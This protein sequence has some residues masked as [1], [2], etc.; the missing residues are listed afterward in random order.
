MGIAN[1]INNSTTTSGGEI[2]RELVNSTDGQGLHFD[3]IAG[4]IDIASP[5]DLGTAF[6]F[7]FVIK[8]DS[9]GTSSKIVDFGDGGRFVI[10]HNTTGLQV[11]PSNAGGWVTLKSPSPLADLEV[12]HLVL[13][14]DGTT[15]TLFDNGN[16][17]ATATIS[18]T[19]IDSC[20]DAKIGSYFDSVTD[21]F[22][23]TIYRTRF[24]NRALSSTEAATA[25]ERADV[26]VADQYGR[27]AIKD[28]SAISSTNWTN[29]TGWGFG[30]GKG[31][32]TQ[33]GAT[34]GALSQTGVFTSADVGKNV[35]IT[36]TVETTTASIF[37]GNAAG[38]T[39]YKG[40]TMYGVGT[41]TVE[42][43]MPSGETTIGFWANGATFT[44]SNISVHVEGCVSDY[45]LAFAN[46]TQSLMVQDRSNAADGTCTASGVTQVQKV[47]QLN[48]T[49]ARIGTTQATPADGDVLI[50]GNA[51][52]GGATDTATFFG[53]TLAIT[54][55][56]NCGVVFKKTTG[57]TKDYSV[58]VKSDGTFNVVD[59]STPR[60]TLDA[61]GNVSVGGSAA[62]KLLTLKKDGGGSQLGIDIHNTG[63]AAGD[64]AVISYE[65]QGVVEWV[66][67]ID[68]S[69]SSF[70]I[71]GSGAD[72]AT[73]PR[74]TIS[75]TGLAS[76]SNGIAF[77]SQT[78]STAGGSITSTLSHYEQGTFTPTDG[79]GAGL[80]FTSVSCNYTRIGRV[81]I[82]TG[83]FVYPTTSSGSQARVTVGT[84]PFAAVGN[85]SGTMTIGTVSGGAGIDAAGY[86]RKENNGG[87]ANSELTGAA[88]YFNTTYITS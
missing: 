50:S 86:I 1:I 26:P 37:I 67:G 87:F 32:F 56:G 7:E 12:H 76:F 75:N 45:D 72:L 18:A 4:N 2:I 19:D 60:I 16:Q 42:F 48:A 71:A 24:Y 34:A 22:N 61:S 83:S 49:A 41:N 8:A 63:T 43:T 47:V 68:R 29:G 23:G 17:T 58:G 66:T 70:V 81:V 14:V 31:T 40:Y 55:A 64:D 84:L 35:R 9:T 21:L 57:T 54:D 82:L 25:F 13:T 11:K 78:N 39:S 51:G 3:G 85:T 62:T 30:S 27:Q 69:A 52:I 74:L 33:A 36:F 46:P 44:I 80:T 77:S 79:S 73:N 53:K 15:A 10:E 38:G 6:S 5:P 28:G 88:I 20:A 59:G 65:C